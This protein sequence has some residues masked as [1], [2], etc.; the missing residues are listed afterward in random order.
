MQAN[1][2]PF[3]EEAL[4]LQGITDY[5]YEVITALSESAKSKPQVE[6]YRILFEFD[7]S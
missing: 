5:D 7:Q 2:D 3:V 6:I 4:R 1:K